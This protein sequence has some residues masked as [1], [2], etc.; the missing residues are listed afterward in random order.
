MR[1]CKRH[2]LGVPNQHTIRRDEL[3]VARRQRA[4][5]DLLERQ[6]RVARRDQLA[7]MGIG[8]HDVTAQVAARRWQTFGPV[9]VVTHNGPPTP[10]QE[11]FVCVLHCG[12]RAALAA[13]TAAAEGGLVGWDAPGVEVVVPRGTTVPD[14][15]DLPLIVHES[16]RFKPQDVHPTASPPRLRM[17]RSLVDAA[18][19]APT[20]RAACG[21]L[22]AGVQQRLTTAAR[23]RKTLLDAGQVRRRQLLLVTLH[24]I[25]GGAAALSEIDFGRLCRRWRLPAHVVRQVVRR[26]RY[27]KRRYL[28]VTLTGPD[29]RTVRVE[30]DGAVHLLVR[31]YWEDMYRQNEFTIA[32][33]PILRFPSVAV[34]IDELTVV[35]QVARA[36]GLPPPVR[37]T[38]TPG[39]PTA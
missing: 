17:E 11:R 9:V 28:D 33:D 25:E 16:R 6:D 29:G 2:Y 27:G 13:R 14:L 7:A 4:L 34:R 37:L 38:T 32:G 3:S 19:W 26:D 18:A 21:I 39:S 20:G 35:D 1:F 22:C 24:D 5:A 36:L 12:K 30:I 10:A 8:A 31:S 23:L 15:A